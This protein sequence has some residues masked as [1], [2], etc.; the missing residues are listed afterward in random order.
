MA[1]QSPDA[2]MDEITDTLIDTAVETRQQADTMRL[3]SIWTGLDMPVPVMARAALAGSDIDAPRIRSG[4]LA[5][6]DAAARAG[7]AGDAVFAGLTET[8]GQPQAL[9]GADLASIVSAVNSFDRSNDAARLALEAGQIW[10]I[11]AR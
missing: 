3:F 6:I 7:A 11:A 5:A 1:S 2:L 8:N 10:T 4:K 9:S